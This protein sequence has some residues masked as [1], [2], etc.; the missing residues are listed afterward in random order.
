MRRHLALGELPR[1]F[2]DRALLL[3]KL[4]IHAAPAAPLAERMIHGLGSAAMVQNISTADAILDTAQRLIQTRGYNAFGY[5][6]IA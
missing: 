4:E 5:R 2:L 3:G 1:R 6:D